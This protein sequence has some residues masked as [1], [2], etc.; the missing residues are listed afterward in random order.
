MTAAPAG[1]RGPAV[2]A[3]AG[4][5]RGLHALAVVLAI[6]TFGLLAAGGVVTSKDAGLSVPDWPLSYGQIN[7]TGWTSTPNVFEEHSHRL[8]GWGAGV[9][10][11]VL[12]TFVEMHERRRW[13]RNL[14]WAT[15]GAVVVQGVIGG[16]FRVVLLQH[17]MA[18]VHGVIGQAFFCLVVAVALFLSR[19]WIEAPPPEG[20]P[21]A[22]RIRRLSLL[23]VAALFLQVVVGA[24]I[25]H[26][27]LGHSIAHV[28]PHILWGVVC[29]VLGLLCMAEALAR[30]GRHPG[31]VRPAL[32]LGGG[33]VLQ[34][35][36]GIGAWQVNRMWV[37]EYVEA[38]E[39]YLRPL[40]LVAG[41][42]AHQAAG[43][44]V[45]AAAVVLHLR[46]RRLLRDPE[47]GRSVVPVP[48]GS[49]A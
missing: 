37:E 26:S 22:R 24:L 9:L 16:Y 5:G 33:V 6:W 35:L 47:T 49:A 4:G 25:R 18:I 46:V 12:V 40:F 23:A 11:L 27:H 21:H 13:V 34:I 42:T 1:P 14:A 36:L 41:T 32:A 43:A 44:L 30:H 45:M 20:N 17:R 3:A 2:A 8:L 19:G 28:W 29:A 38:G 10:V 48:A 39:E 31:I 15:L 7:P